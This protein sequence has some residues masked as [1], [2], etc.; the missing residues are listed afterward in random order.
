MRSRRT[1]STIF[2]LLFALIA[3]IPS[4][5]TF[6]QETSRT[7]LGV[8]WQ[9]NPPL[10]ELSTRLAQYEELGISYIEVTHPVEPATLDSLSSYPF[11]VLIRFDNQFLI[12]EDI[13]QGKEEFIQKYQRLILKYAEYENVIA[14]GL[15]SFSQSFNAEFITEFSAIKEELRTIT[16]REFYEITSGNFNAVDF[17]ITL[18]AGDS[19]SE[20]S[21][22]FLLSRSYEKNDLHLFHKLIN[23]KPVLLFLDGNWLDEAL[24]D[25]FP[26]R[27]SLVSLKESGAFTLPLPKKNNPKPEFNWPVLVFVLIWVSLG[28]HI[29]LSQTYKPL[30]FRFFSAHRFFVDDVMRYRER[31]FLSGTFLVFQ[32]A[33]FTGLVLYILS[34][35]LISPKG[36]DALFYFLPQAAFFGE[37]YFSVFAVTMMISILLQLVGLFWL[38]LPSK[39][40]THFSQALNLYT[41]IFH[42]D[43]L[44]VS[45]MLI[46]LLSGGSRAVIIILGIIFVLNWLM[47]F[48]LTA[49]DSSKYLAQKRAGY[50][51]YTFGLHTLA[52][53]ALLV[54]ILSNDYLMDV[55]ELLFVL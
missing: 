22:S 8:S 36:L 45:I 39:S 31:S 43:F 9:N 28:I 12:A 29:L 19:I 30:I 53:I 23:K 6:A 46:L 4:G 15:Y 51:L 40:M 47:G 27:E 17:S 14:Y 2:I 33:A 49:F 11:R 18:I 10:N 37:N 24:S 7:N 52:N 38:Y 25:Y 3:G 5:F 34:A 41:W 21:P 26:L 55:L 13:K 54:F 1:Y 16:N 20:N 42:I 50:I 44:L 32:H 35:L 48:L